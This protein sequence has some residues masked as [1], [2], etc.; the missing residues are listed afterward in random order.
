MED[1]KILEKQNFIRE[2]ITQLKRA[3]KLLSPNI[4]IRWA[5]L[6]AMK[7]E[8]EDK[9]EQE[10]SED[11]QD[12]ARSGWISIRSK[13]ESR[14]EKEENQFTRIMMSTKNKTKQ[15]NTIQ[16]NTIQYNT[17]QNNTI[18]Y[19]TIQYIT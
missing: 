16:Y 13:Q 15:Y 12:R 19:N 11:H 18:Q 6:V 7:K 9:K 1:Q 3:E 17:I 14:R 10:E 8:K 2:S 5:D 4:L